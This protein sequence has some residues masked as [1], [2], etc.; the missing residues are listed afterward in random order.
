MEKYISLKTDASYKE[1][2]GC[3]LSYE[4]E[5][6]N[7]EGIQNIK[8]NRFSKDIKDSTEG[9]LNATVY[10]IIKVLKQI[11]NPSEYIIS[12]SSD[13]EYV[14][15]CFQ[16]RYPNQPTVVKTAFN[17]L[18]LFAGWNMK[19]IP[20]VKNAKADALAKSALMKAEDQL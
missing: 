15:N 17:I 12:V 20:R 19:W 3:G 11:N 13:C 1:K 18:D 4:F 9:E 2:V 6:R 8:G 5:I 7:E 14:I 10:G 16:Q